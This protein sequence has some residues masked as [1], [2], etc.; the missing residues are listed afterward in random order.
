M[1]RHPSL[2]SGERPAQPGVAPFDPRPAVRQPAPPPPSTWL[3]PLS[4][5]PPVVGDDQP[6]EVQATERIDTGD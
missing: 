3:E 5:P 4:E 6:L 1:S 2:S